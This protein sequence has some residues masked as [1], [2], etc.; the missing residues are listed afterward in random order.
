[1][2]NYEDDELNIER[3]VFGRSIEISDTPRKD[4]ET[5][6]LEYEKSYTDVED[7]L[8]DFKTGVIPAVEEPTIQLEPVSPLEKGEPSLR[9]TDTF[10]DIVDDEIQDEKAKKKKGAEEDKSNKKSKKRKRKKKHPFLV[11][12]CLVAI[13]FG[14]YEFAMSD[15]FTVRNIEVE[16]NHYY[17]VSQV[18][19]MAGIP[20]GYNLF[21]TDVSSAK[22]ALLQDPYIILVSIK[23]EPFDTI[24][25]VIEEREEYAAVPYG[26]EYI[27]IDKTGMVLRITDNEPAY[28]LLVGMTIIEMT[29]GKPLSVE[30]SYLLTN[31]LELLGVMKENDLYFKRVN[32]STVVVKAYI[33]DDLYC[34]G[35][36]GNITGSMSA[37]RQLVSQLYNEGT[38]RG[39]IKVGKDNYLSFDPQID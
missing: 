2:A 33:Y 26:E 18:V 16:G 39:V 1:V 13:G 6:A 37:V 35:T 24:K 30:Q 25:V 31:T 3:F 27:L 19:D 8:A 20:T 17:T 14:L 22:D 34:E 12:L 9:F 36:P 15:F 11:F 32:F 10:M 21:K 28:P 5:A 38:T 23:K 4:A 7:L 29:P